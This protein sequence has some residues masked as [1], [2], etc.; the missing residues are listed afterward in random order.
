MRDALS[1]ALRTFRQS[2]ASKNRVLVLL[3]DGKSTD[4]DPRF[5]GK[6]LQHEKVKIATV[7][8]TENKAI[9]ERRLY[10]Q[11]AETFDEGQLALFELASRVSCV[12][13][14]IPVLTS[15]GWQI[16][17]SGECALY[18]SV[19]S[20]TVLDEFCSML[21]SARFGSTNELLD[22]IGR[23]RQDKFVNDEHVR[24]RQIPFEQEES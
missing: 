19:C 16:P 11:K 7:Y 12:M 13:R 2:P 6:D 9:P 14:P 5:L 15:S 24:T 21:L 10:Y 17:S 3:S 22:I 23:D 4:G 20:T 8:L 1:E 18:V